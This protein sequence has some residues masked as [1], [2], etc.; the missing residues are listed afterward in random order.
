[1]KLLLDTHALLWMSDASGRLSAKAAATIMDGRN[2]LLL[3]VASWWE[4]AIKI[5][6]GKLE[7]KSDWAPALKREMRHNGITWLSVRPDH[8]ERV[9]LLPFHH[10][11]PFDRL[12]VAQA[13]VEKLAVVT[14]D[15]HFAPYGIDVVW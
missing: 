3:S 2:D 10:R 9:C 8:C 7:L 6:L 15:P 4:I 14:A 5:S 1:M 11:D 13:Q 12:L